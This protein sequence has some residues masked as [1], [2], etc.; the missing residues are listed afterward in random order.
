M[1][2]KILGIM[3]VL[4]VG[5]VVPAVALANDI[6][7]VDFELLFYAHPEYDVK[8]EELQTKVE[9]LYEEMQAQAETLQTQEE[10]DELSSFFQWQFDQIEQEVRVELVSFI[11]DIIKEVAKANSI[12]TVLPE[13]SIIYGGINLTAPVVEAMYKAYGISVPSSIREV[14]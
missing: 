1:N 12:S 9:E 8:N 4:I 7:Y 6:G 5:L 2:K 14:L 3:L 13:S 10:L 11:L